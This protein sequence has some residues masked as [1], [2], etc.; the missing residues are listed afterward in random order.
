MT[1]VK[2]SI[3]FL[4]KANELIH[5]NSTQFTSILQIGSNYMNKCKERFLFCG[6]LAV[7]Y[8]EGKEECE[9]NIHS[10]INKRHIYLQER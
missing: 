10:V 4:V 7:I 8:C 3:Y 5:S 1:N 6:L 2:Y 9:Y